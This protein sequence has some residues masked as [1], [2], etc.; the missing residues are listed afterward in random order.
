VSCLLN[1]KYKDPEEKS[2]ATIILGYEAM[3]YKRGK[4]DIKHNLDAID[5]FKIKLHY[6]NL[7]FY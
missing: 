4:H 7:K 5:L 3:E 6:Y 2:L 1:N